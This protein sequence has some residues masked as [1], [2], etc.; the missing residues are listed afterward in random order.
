MDYASL[1]HHP[2]VTKENLNRGR[3]LFIQ[4]LYSFLIYSI[5]LGV[6]TVLLSYLA[7]II[8]QYTTQRQVR[9]EEIHG[10]ND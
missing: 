4:A 7:T 6:I 3:E 1:Q 5:I 2:N 9:V 10:L 8:F